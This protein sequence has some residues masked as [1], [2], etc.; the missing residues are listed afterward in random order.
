MIETTMLSGTNFRDGIQSTRESSDLDGFIPNLFWIIIGNPYD[1]DLWTLSYVL[2]SV[3][4]S[5]I[6]RPFSFRIFESCSAWKKR[7]AV[8]AFLIWGAILDSVFAYYFNCV[9]CDASG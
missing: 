7:K 6:A 8:L 3:M 4:A 9:D 5:P 2:T 1:I